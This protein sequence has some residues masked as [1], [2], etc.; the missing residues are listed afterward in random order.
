MFASMFK[1][2]TAMIRDNIAANGKEF[3]TI[4]G[5][6]NF[7]E[8]FEVKGESLRNVPKG[9][10]PVHPQA[11]YLKNKSWYL[12]YPV[13]DESFADGDGFVKQAAQIFRYMKPFNDFL[14]SALRD[15]Q[16]PSR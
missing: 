1:D 12:E 11:E 14:N 10:D 5:G 7:T 15:F 8:Y 6:R 4:V 16:M 3:E 13:S 9:Y 2:A